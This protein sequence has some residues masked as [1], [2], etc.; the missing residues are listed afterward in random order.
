MGRTRQIDAHTP[1][2]I[3]NTVLYV[4]TT[5]LSSH[6]RIVFVQ[7]WFCLYTCSCILETRL[8]VNGGVRTEEQCVVQG[9]VM[10]RDVANSVRDEMTYLPQRKRLQI[11]GSMGYETRHRRG[12]LTKK[13]TIIGS[14]NRNTQGNGNHISSGHRHFV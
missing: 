3:S 14:D 2:C 5:N 13:M 8:V 1:V 6:P 7:W 10:A 9:L 4:R 11:T 12:R